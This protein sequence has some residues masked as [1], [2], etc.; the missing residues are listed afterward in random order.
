MDGIL[1]NRTFPMRGI[2]F[3]KNIDFLKF[4]NTYSQW[5]F[6]IRIVCFITTVF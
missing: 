4:L 3:S 6:M 1:K 5:V 2:K